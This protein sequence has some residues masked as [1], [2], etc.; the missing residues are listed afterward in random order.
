MARLLAAAVRRLPREDGVSLLEYSVLRAFLALSGFVAMS[1][2]GIGI[3]SFFGKLEA[4]LD[5]L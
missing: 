5:T 1:R 2:L 4:Y 3:S